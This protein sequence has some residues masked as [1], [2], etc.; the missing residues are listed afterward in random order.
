MTVKTAIVT[1]VAR[2]TV[3]T[4][5]FTVAGFG[6]VK[7]AICIT[8][9]GTNEVAIVTPL[10][11]SF[12]F[13]DTSSTFAGSMFYE[14]AST[15]ATAN[16]AGF[17]GELVALTNLAGGREWS[18]DFNMTVVDGIQLNWTDVATAP[19][20]PLVV[21]LLFGGTDLSVKAITDTTP[22]V[23][24][25]KDITSV[26]FEAELVWIMSTHNAAIPYNDTI[27]SGEAAI[28]IGM[29]SND[30][31]GGVE[32]RCI[33]MRGIDGG[34]TQDGSVLASDTR[35]LVNVDA[36][37]TS[38]EVSLEG[39]DSSGF[40]LRENDT[41]TAMPFAAFCIGFGIATV[42]HLV[43]DF[44]TA[45][46]G[47]LAVTTPGFKPQMV[48]MLPTLAFSFDSL[49]TSG[50]DVWALS[51]AMVDD[52]FRELSSDVFSK[53]GVSTSATGGTH[54]AKF[55][56]ITDNSGVVGL[57]ADFASFDDLGFSMDWTTADTGRKIMYMA[58]GEGPPEP[59]IL[60]Q[61]ESSTG[62]SE[63]DKV[64][65]MIIEADTTDFISDPPEGALTVTR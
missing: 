51:L 36:A 23:V 7:G 29:V 24:G 9:T 34:A 52:T 10:R 17:S 62:A 19:F 46:N 27:T 31:A 5:D 64:S 14:T 1:Q 58:L 20:A 6:P 13:T 45:G 42:S 2:T 50:S 21:V 47:I 15:T 41:A 60:L 8:T 65:N 26:G 33:N 38:Q 25:T 11:F 35:A 18:A 28:S 43:E 61:R 32:N 57:E 39:F 63:V 37:G 3:G 22:A 48:F 55:P 56:L 49:D 12:G 54:R 44:D 59:F 53:D 30:K 16:T 40:T 4:Q